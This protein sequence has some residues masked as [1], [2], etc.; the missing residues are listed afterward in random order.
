ME[1]YWIWLSQRP[2]M[3]KTR[4][5]KLIKVFGDPKAVWQAEESALQQAGITEE[6][7]LTGLLDKDLSEAERICQVC[8]RNGW[9]VLD[10]MHPHYPG[11]LKKI[12]D[13]PL[14]L[15][16]WGSIPAVDKQ[17]T[18]GVV[19]TRNAGA[20][21]L[22]QTYRLSGQLAS[23]GA[24]VISGGALGVD[25]EALKAALDAGQPCIAVIA[26]G[27]DKLYPAQN[28]RLFARIAQRGCVLTQYT[29]GTPCQKFQFLERNRLISGLSDGVL[30]T[31]AP[32]RS[33]AMSTARHAKTQGRDL[34]AMP[35]PISDANFGGCHDLIRNSG[36]VLVEE[37][38]H[39]LTVYEERYPKQ[40]AGAPPVIPAADRETGVPEKNKIDK[41][42]PGAYTERHKEDPN[43]D[44]PGMRILRLLQDGPMSPEQIARH[45]A[46]G[47]GQ[48]QTLLLELELDGRVDRRGNLYRVTH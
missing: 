10:I 41:K 22:R 7:L 14:V 29:P 30:V 39:I 31:E 26:G 27:L 48:V 43:P 45:L 9:T 19:G 25:T 28:E 40:E 37:G 24:V 32:L 3:T 35:G 1:Q 13:A 4:A 16:V 12:S 15:Y 34:Y 11:K 42:S 47:V 23:G 44:S 5:A 8:R 21:G 2:G 18:I 17:I 33:G 38:A 36:A 46:I 6:K 20:Y